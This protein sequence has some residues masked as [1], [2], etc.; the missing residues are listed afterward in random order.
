[1]F[2][3]PTQL[4]MTAAFFALASPL[5]GCSSDGGGSTS[6]SSGS[7]SGTTPSPGGSGGGSSGAPTDPTGGSDDTGGSSGG[8]AASGTGADKVGSQCVKNADCPSNACLF[9]KDAAFGYCSK[10]CQ[11]FAECPTFWS[12]EAVQNGSSKYCTQK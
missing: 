7:S 5:L 1:M 6:S 3:H 12:C 8:G 4:F 11:S 10:T 2:S 9:K